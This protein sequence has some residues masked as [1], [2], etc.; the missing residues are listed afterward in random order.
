MKKTIFLLYFIAAS[1]WLFG[2][3]VIL[4]TDELARL[5]MASINRSTEEARLAAADTFAMLLD[6]ML[7]TKAGFAHHFDAVKNLSKLTSPDENFRIFTWSVPLKNG[8]FAF[9]GRLVLKQDNGF[10]RVELVD[11]AMNLENPEFNLSKPSQWYGAVYYEIITVSDQKKTYYT[12]LGYRPDNSSHAEKVIDVID[13]DNLQTLRFGAKIF[14]TP[15][16]NGVKY[17]RPPHR[18]ILRYNP[19]ITV[20]LRYHASEKQIVMDHLSPPDA[21]QRSMWQLYGPD[22]TYDALVWKKGMWQLKERIK[23][24]GNAADKKKKAKKRKKE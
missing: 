14:N 7:D 6:G 9:F 22:F 20:L 1:G 21:S 2:Q 5:G 13:A 19:K 16:I 11:N 23:V 8:S 12:L 4:E 24:A 17:E 3:E 10:K 15:A 18:I